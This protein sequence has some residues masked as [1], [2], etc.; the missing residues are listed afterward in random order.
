VSERLTLATSTGLPFLALSFHFA[1][2]LIALVAGFLAVAVRKGSQLHRWSGVVF[3]CAMI[4]T[5]LTVTGIY[6]YQGKWSSTGGISI[7]Y[8]VLT[9][10]TAVKQLPG[11]GRRVAIALAVLAF[12]IAA[13]GYYWGVVAF[14][15]P[16]ASIDGAPAGMILF[17]STILLFAA[18]G[19]VRM[20][21]A[22]GIHGTRKV[23]RHLWRMC[24]ALF[25]ASGSFF[26]GQMK[27][28]PEPLRS[29]PLMIALGVSPL[30]ILLYWMWRV[31]LRQN[32]KGMLTAKPIE[33]R[34][35]A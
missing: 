5:G 30:A 32:L 26:I 16:G 19:D 34:Q 1:T 2:G 12:A 35:P 17:L 18:I 21:R 13:N 27:F 8:W 14:G 7:V 11:L 25:I 10:Y 29:L 4:A 6:M 22:G 3:V 33:A 31:R 9:A 23:A 15:R 20:I 24:F 28:L